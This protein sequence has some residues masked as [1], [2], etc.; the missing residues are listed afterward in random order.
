VA[1]NPA[2]DSVFSWERNNAR[3]ETFCLEVRMHRC[4]FDR[5]NHRVAEGV[6]RRSEGLTGL[7]IALGLFPDRY[8]T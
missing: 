6:D 8:L 3:F 7:L 5:T 1:T 2:K 4:R